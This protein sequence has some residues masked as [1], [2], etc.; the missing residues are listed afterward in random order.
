MPNTERPNPGGKGQS[1]F[2]KEEPR[3]NPPQVSNALT[4]SHLCAT[5]AIATGV[6]SAETP[7]NSL[8]HVKASAF[9]RLGTA[10][11]W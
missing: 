7:D 11:A 8:H 10:S 1:A 9:L 4:V 5:I 6:L 3:F 2:E